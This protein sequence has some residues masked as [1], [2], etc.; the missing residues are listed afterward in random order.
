MDPVTALGAAGSVVG[1]AGFGIQ[2]YQILSKFV[3]QVRSAQEQLEGVIAEIDSTTSALEE[4]YYYLEKEVRN[5]ETGKQLELFSESSLV[6][7]K[8]TADKCLV[9]FWRIETVI[10]GSEPDGFDDELASRLTRFNRTL[11]SYCMGHTIKIESQLTSDPLRFRDKVRW[12][13]HSSKV[14]R[15]CKELQRYQSH[16]GLLLQIVLLGQQQAKQY[17]LFCLE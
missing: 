6:K 4:I 2:L 12:A 17:V 10:A 11:A 5:V 7:V 15:F 13:F 8:V 3:S 16:L 9:V 14:E 1:I